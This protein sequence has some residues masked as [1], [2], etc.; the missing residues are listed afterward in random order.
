MAEALSVAYARNK[1]R[2]YERPHPTDLCYPLT[3]FTLLA[4]RPDL[5]VEGGHLLI[6]RH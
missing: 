4:E 2:R 6:Q 1:G 3:G 5:L